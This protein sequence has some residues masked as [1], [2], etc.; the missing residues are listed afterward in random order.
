MPGIAIVYIHSLPIKI[1]VVCLSLVHGQVHLT[2]H[3]GMQFGSESS[4]QN[5]DNLIYVVR[6]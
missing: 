5:K 6:E 3:N 1:K 2:Q 4:K